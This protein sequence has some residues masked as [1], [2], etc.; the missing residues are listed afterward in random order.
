[1]GKSKQEVDKLNLTDLQMEL[2]SIE[3]HI[4]QLHNEIEK[5]KPQA[6]EGKKKDYESIDRLAKK[7]AVEHTRLNRA[8]EYVKKTFI[9]GLAYL[10]AAEKT[11]VHDRLLYLTRLSVG[12][13]LDM[14]SEEIYKSGI[15]FEAADIEG[16]CTNLTEY[17]YTYIVEALI[18]ANLSGEPPV[19]MLSVI[20]D[21]AQ[22]MGLD[23][24]EIQVT[25]QV[26]KAKLTDNMDILKGLPVLSENRWSNQFADYIPQEWLIKQRIKCGRLLDKLSYELGIPYERIKS[27]FGEE[28]CSGKITTCLKDGSIVKKGD[29]LCSY[30][31]KSRGIV[32][33]FQVMPLFLEGKDDFL[34]EKEEKNLTAPCGGVVYSIEEKV[35]NKAADTTAVFRTVY[36]VSYFDDYEAICKWYKN[37][38]K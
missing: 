16:L 20:A 8:E 10:L 29:I 1:M 9:R 6:Q 28:E 34:F 3:E 30:R 12:C 38:C 15:E 2:R 27:S 11:E 13:G 4:S 26:A 31:E 22:T 17:K 18:I 14:T 24:E 19:H 21:I 36:V 23:K 32:T 35:D 37:G 25:A 5:M 33:M 7:H